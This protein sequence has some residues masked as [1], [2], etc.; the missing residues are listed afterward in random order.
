MKQKFKA[1]SVGV[2]CMGTCVVAEDIPLRSS[3]VLFGQ[4]DLEALARGQVLTFFDNG[5]SQF[6]DDG[7]YTYTYAN[8]GGVV[9]G[10]FEVTDE[11]TICIEFVNGFSRC[12][13]YVTD[14]QG[15]LVVITERGDRFPVRP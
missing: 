1:L 4:S 14:V 5:Q 7:R 9:Y 12:G 3:D 6:Y 10:Y 15:R 13:A 8:D 2:A 11:S